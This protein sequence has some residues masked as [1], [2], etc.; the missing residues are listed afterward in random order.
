MY[1]M[2]Y[3]I[4]P[5]NGKRNAYYSL[6]D[7]DRWFSFLFPI[8]AFENSRGEMLNLIFAHW[9]RVHWTLQLILIRLYYI[10]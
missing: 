1:K 9:G 3:I 4:L 7:S 10:L 2:D 5:V 8:L 6:K